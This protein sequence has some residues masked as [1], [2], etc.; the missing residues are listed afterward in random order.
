[1]SGEEMAGAERPWGTWHV[2]DSGQ[3]YKVKRIEVRP[4]HRLSYQTHEHR[5]EH[6][7]V[8]AGVATCVL[9]GRKVTARAGEHVDVGQHV[10][11]RICNEG[12]DLLVIIETQLGPYTEED[13]IVRLADD[14]DRCQAP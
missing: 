13:D 10:P 5:S 8:V 4:G 3:G 14:Y 6:W 2:L 9:D 1:M 12:A 11:H 7:L